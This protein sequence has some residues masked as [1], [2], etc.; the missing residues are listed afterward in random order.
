MKWGLLIISCYQCVH[1]FMPASDVLSCM[2]L[3]LYAVFA[4]VFEFYLRLKKR[5][6]APRPA[7]SW[8]NWQ[9]NHVSAGTISVCVCLWKMHDFSRG[10]V[11]P[12]ESCPPHP[13]AH[14]WQENGVS[15]LWKKTGSQESEP[16]SYHIEQSPS[17]TLQHV[18]GNE[19]LCFCVRLVCQW[20]PPTCLLTWLSLS[21]MLM[22]GCFPLFL[23]PCHTHTHKSIW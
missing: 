4:C 10:S 9:V 17:K 6:E 23:P 13:P 11:W 16:Q 21:P 18:C 22:C 15:L 7:A 1:T 3:Y 8:S 5:G 19:E 20:P 14:H 12:W 2:A